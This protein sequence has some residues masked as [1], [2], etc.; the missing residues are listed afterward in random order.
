MLQYHTTF[1][2]TISQCSQQQH[3]IRITSVFTIDSFDDYSANW[4][5]R[6]NDHIPHRIDHLQTPWRQQGLDRCYL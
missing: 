1:A 6:G 4:V 2:E 5:H 3:T